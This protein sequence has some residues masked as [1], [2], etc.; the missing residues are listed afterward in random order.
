[1]I[2]NLFKSGLKN[3]IRNKLFFVI[4][5]LG[6]SLGISVSLVI[7]IMV[8]FDYSHD[9]FHPEIDRI[10]R[11][12]SESDGDGSMAKTAAIQGPFYNAMMAEVKGIEEASPLIRVNFKVNIIEGSTEVKTF[13]N[14]YDMVIV[15][16]AY[17]N[18]FKYRWLLGDIATLTNPYCVVLTEDRAKKYFKGL[19]LSQIIGKAITYNDSLKVKVVGIVQSLPSNSELIF[20][21]FISYAT[22]SQTNLKGHINLDTWSSLNSDHQLLVKLWLSTNTHQV[23]KDLLGLRHKHLTIENDKTHYILQKFADIHFDTTYGN[24]KR[25]VADRPT[26]NALIIVALFFI[27]LGCS[28]F[29]ILSTA[30][31]SMRTKEIGIRKV[32][33]SSARLLATQYLIEVFYLVGFALLLSIISVPFFIQLFRNFIPAEIR[34]S[35]LFQSHVFLFAIFLSVF[36]TLLGG[37]YPALLM[38][39]FHP[40]AAI[41]GGMLKGSASFILIRKGLVLVQLITALLFILSFLVVFK[42]LKYLSHKDL[43]FRKNAIIYFS[44]PLK[45]HIG[46]SSFILANVFKEKLNSIPGIELVS[47]GGEPPSASS[48]STSEI[49]YPNGNSNIKINSQVKSGDSLFFKLYQIPLVIGRMPRYHLDSSFGEVVINET[50]AQQLGVDDYSKLI[51]TS[52]GPGTKAKIVGICK[53][54]NMRSLHAPIMP[55]YLSSNPR[56]CNLYHIGLEENGSKSQDLKILTQ[57]KSYYQE[58]F[59]GSEF[60]YTFLDEELSMFYLSEQHISKLIN[61]CMVLAIFVCC[62]GLYGLMMHTLRTRQKEI[63][64]RKVIGASVENIVLLFFYEF[65]RIFLVALVIA[66]PF[67]YLYGQKWLNSY[68]YRTE[69]SLW[70]FPTGGMIL[71]LIVMAIFRFTIVQAAKANPIKALRMN[72]V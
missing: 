2:L 1:M 37:L 15:E 12:V 33:G 14:Q 27:I 39:R 43:G 48:S 9:R 31:A 28:N 46:K 24:Y 38:S 13:N 29:I 20:Q 17:F 60:R 47:L 6:L 68:A 62:I 45:L 66:S 50:L 52:F 44:A 21:D 5:L 35:S 42:Q 32:L 23:E 7:Y 67:V 16:P 69:I 4:N 18:I 41:K 57:I 30:E 3:L 59:P 10:Y 53:D 11:I 56:R 63:G 61:W 36:V 19:D 26:T 25:R 54:F 51:G 65:V 40:I 22:F 71:L 72:D 64:I 34:L 55:M 49:D 70:L 8:Q 58:L